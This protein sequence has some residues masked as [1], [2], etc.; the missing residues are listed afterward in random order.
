MIC[1]AI[2]DESA[3]KTS[4]MS[5]VRGSRI[6]WL[7]RMKYGITG[8]LGIAWLLISI[9]YRLSSFYVMCNRGRS[10]GITCPRWSGDMRS[11]R[12]PRRVVWTH[13]EACCTLQYD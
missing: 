9:D 6:G 4:P 12:S 2:I 7:V 11:G 10:G 5:A 13:V 3:D 8:F 1:L